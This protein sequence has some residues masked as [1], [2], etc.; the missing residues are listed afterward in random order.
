MISDSEISYLEEV[1]VRAR[2]TRR[3]LIGTKQPSAAKAAELVLL[4]YAPGLIREL[5]KARAKLASLKT[6]E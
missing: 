6:A 2:K 1:C 4:A 5:K 3:S